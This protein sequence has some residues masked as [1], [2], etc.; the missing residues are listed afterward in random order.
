VSTR[1][2]VVAEPRAI[3]G[4]KVARLRR[5]GILP[6]V[7]FGHGH[8][9]Q[10]IQLDARSFDILRRRVG[11]N[12][13]VDLKVGSSRA[14]PVLLQ[15]VAEH[16]V[17]RQA[18]HVDFFVVKM[19][20][21][22]TVDVPVTTAGEAPAASRMGG[23]LLLMRDAVQVRALP[24]ELPSALELD[25]TGLD[26]FDAVLHVR[27]L[28]VPPRVTLLTDADEVLAKVQAPRVEAEAPEEVEV[29]EEEAAEAGETEGP[30]GTA[31]AA[32][33]PPAGAAEG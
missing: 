27:D 7:V 24:T 30:E 17:G 5:Q 18:V 13:L 4:K 3:V 1:P 28:V 26:S 12:V 19:S 15:H 25:V 22:M 9:S 16:P 6:G 21:E 29:G 32:T 23:T 8:D 11:R 31:A 10:A 2:L 20:E 33:A 14:T